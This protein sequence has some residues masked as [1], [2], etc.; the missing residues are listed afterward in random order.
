MIDDSALLQ[1]QS[2]HYQAKL[3]QVNGLMALDKRQNDQVTG[4][5]EELIALVRLQ[6]QSLGELT[7]AAELARKR[8]MEKAI[9]DESG[10]VSAILMGRSADMERAA[11]DNTFY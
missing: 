3:S 4:K 1:E 6:R 5:L 7:K 2:D 8:T 10:K 9:N 11:M